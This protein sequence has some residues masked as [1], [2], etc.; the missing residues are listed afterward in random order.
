MTLRL[1]NKTLKV[2]YLWKKKDLNIGIINKYWRKRSSLQMMKWKYRV[3]CIE[4]LWEK[5][6]KAPTLTCHSVISD[7]KLSYASN[8][9]FDVA[10][11]LKI[12]KNTNFKWGLPDKFFRF[13]PNLT[14]FIPHRKAILLTFMNNFMY[15]PLFNHWTI[16]NPGVNIYRMA[17]TPLI[18]VTMIK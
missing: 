15:F 16:Y 11:N 6:V 14:S 8:T 13:Y 4:W 2:V 10:S 12:L 3:W 17:P 9:T 1:L 7:I 5:M 18:H